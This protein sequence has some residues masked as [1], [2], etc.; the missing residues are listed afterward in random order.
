MLAF[1]VCRQRYNHGHPV[2]VKYGARRDMVKVEGRGTKKNE[3][4]D[5][6]FYRATANRCQVSDFKAKMH[7]NRFA[8]GLI[9]EII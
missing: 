6:N 8:Y 4:G 7:Q 2:N 5:F 3:E 1:S 9:F